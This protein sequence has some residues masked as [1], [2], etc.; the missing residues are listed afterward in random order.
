MVSLVSNN[1][2]L[3][4]ITKLGFSQIGLNK[5]ENELILDSVPKDQFVRAT[6]NYQLCLDH[7][8]D[9]DE[10]LRPSM[11]VYMEGPFV[12]SMYNFGDDL[13]KSFLVLDIE[14]QKSKQETGGIII[15]DPL[16]WTKKSIGVFPF[17]DLFRKEIER[18]AERSAKFLKAHK[19]VNMN[20]VVA[21]RE[22]NLAKS[23]AEVFLRQLNPDQH[24]KENITLGKEAVSDTL[25]SSISAQNA[26]YEKLWDKLLDF[27]E[28]SFRH[29][30]EQHALGKTDLSSMAEILQPQAEDPSE[31]T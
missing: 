12:L 13:S 24:G 8:E 15:D 6:A 19:V 25:A 4:Q 18:E 21:E 16:D 9:I 26:F 23:M 27:Y 29:L 3:S 5:E 7:I 11:K 17:V 22:K 10:T 20:D 1:D 14:S 2:H 30:G 28:P 31:P